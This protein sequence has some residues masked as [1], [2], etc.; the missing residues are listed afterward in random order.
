MTLLEKAMAEHPGLR[1][2]KIVSM[3]CPADLGYSDATPLCR[4]FEEAEHALCWDC[5][6]REAPDGPPRAS[7]PTDNG[8]GADDGG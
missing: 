5:W 8:G 4:E 6:N 7:A 3:M 2:G 1:E